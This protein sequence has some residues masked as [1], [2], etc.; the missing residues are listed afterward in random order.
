MTICEK[1]GVRLGTVIVGV[2][3]SGLMVLCPVRDNPD[4]SDN[5]HLWQGRPAVP[6][7]LPR[8]K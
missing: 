3:T 2:L 6:S 8:R 5:L 7:V 1:C 4:Q